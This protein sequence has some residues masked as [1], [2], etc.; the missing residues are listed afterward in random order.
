MT[1]RRIVVGVV[2]VALVAAAVALARGGGADDEAAAPVQTARARRGSLVVLAAAS[3]AVEANV[4]VEVKSRASGVVAELPVRPGDRVE[5]GQLLVRLDPTDEERGVREAES[6]EVSARARLAQAQAGLAA[7]SSEASQALGKTARR[8]EALARGLVSAEEEQS[9]RGAAEVAKQQV[10]LRQA[11][12]R[13]NRAELERAALAISEA[14][15]RLEETVIRAPISGTVLS[16]SV[17]PGATVSSGIT[18]VGGGTALLTLADLSRLRVI[19]KVDEAQVG[20]VKSGQ[21]ASIRVDSHPDREFEGSVDR[22]HPLG[23]TVSSVV[24]FDVE[25]TVSD[26][27]ASLLMPGMTA[28]VEIEAGRH[29][30]VLL[31]PLAALRSERRARFVLLANGERRPVR[32]G[33]TDGTDVVILEGLTPGEE[34]IVA[35]RPGKG[36]EQRKKGGLTDMFRPRGRR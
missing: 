34:V 12:I 25:V 19:A 33:P 16:V 15:R 11:E 6:N 22:V 10:T 23:T 14:R 36:D 7:A 24:T 26:P 2:L 27:Q 29:D 21:R 9:A 13:A 20:Q 17:Q 5:Q 30:D 31:V 4:Q 3:G 32:S 35:G 1:R 28:D 8:T 18:T